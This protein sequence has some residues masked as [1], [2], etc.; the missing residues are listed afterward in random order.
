MYLNVLE[1]KR[2]TVEK[3]DKGEGFKIIVF[4]K[5]ITCTKVYVGKIA[6]EHVKVCVNKHFKL[7]KF[8]L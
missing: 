3:Y 6:P 2:I 7:F 1:R 4:S 8:Y 5:T